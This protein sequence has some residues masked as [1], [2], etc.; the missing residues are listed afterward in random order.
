MRNNLAEPKLLASRFE[1]LCGQAG[2]FRK[3]FERGNSVHRLRKPGIAKGYVEA[4][5]V[6]AVHFNVPAPP[7]KFCFV[8]LRVPP[9][10]KNV[11]GLNDTPMDRRVSCRSDVADDCQANGV[12]VVRHLGKGADYVVTSGVAVASRVWLMVGENIPEP[13]INSTCL[14]EAVQVGGASSPRVVNAS[15]RPPGGKVSCR[16]GCFI[17]SVPSLSQCLGS[18]SPE[19]FRQG[20][21]EADFLDVL[22][23]CRI[24]LGNNFCHAT[25]E[26]P[27]K[28]SVKLVDCLIC[29]FDRLVRWRKLSLDRLTHHRDAVES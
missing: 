22:T 13:L 19:R 6:I 16:K 4:K 17:E 9:G 11:H 5:L 15:I 14:E 3:A 27:L 2:L 18:F 21:C 23:S 26:K 28:S 20:F 8:F 12:F 10:H 29:P 1:S 25:L 24:E 7:Y